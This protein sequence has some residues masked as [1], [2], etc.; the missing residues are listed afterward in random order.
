MSLWTSG[1]LISASKLNQKEIFIGSSAPASP[2]NGQLWFDTT[3]TVLK[4]YDNNTWRMVQMWSIVLDDTLVSV[5]GTSEQERK[6][7][8]FIKSSFMQYKKMHVEATL[9]SSN[10]SGTAYMRV[11]L[12]SEGTAR[13]TLNTT[14]TT[15]TVLSG[16]IDISDLTNGIHTLRVKLNNSGS[17]T[18]NQKLF[19]AVVW[20]S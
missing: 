16:D 7:F 3:N 6:F 9:W 10:A 19:H 12:N 11:Y 13:L 2:T 5:A 20:G 4:I 15:E 14:S 17:Y 8:R 18:T 1:E